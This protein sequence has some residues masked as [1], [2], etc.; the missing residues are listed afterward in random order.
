[1]NQVKTLTILGGGPAGLSAAYYAKK[2]GIDFKLYE[3][4]AK[5]GGN[6]KT[7]T[8]G[9][10]KFDT[11]A[12]RLHGKD[13]AVVDE[14][15]G[16]LGNDI[17]EIDRPS[18]IFYNGKF[19]HFPFTP[20]EVFSKLSP[21]T[22]MKAALAFLI[23]NRNQ[24]QLSFRDIAEAKYGSVI[25]DLF[26]NNYS[27]KLWGLPTNELSPK[28]SGSRLKHLNLQTLLRDIFLPNAVPKHMEG[29]FYYPV[30]GFG[31]IAEHLAEY[32]GWENIELNRRVSSFKHEG[33]RIERITTADGSQFEV[34]QVVSSLPLTLMIRLLDPLPPTEVLDIVENVTFR[35]VTLICFFLKKES[36][37]PGATI[38]FPSEKF[39]FTRGYE[40]RNRSAKMSPD[41]MTSFVVEVPSAAM[42]S[43]NKDGL[44]SRIKNQLIGCGLF[45]EA[46]IIDTT[47]YDIP[48]AYPVLRV[49]IEKDVERLLDYLSQYKNLHITG[50]NGLFEYSW[51]HDMMTIG[52]QTINALCK[53][54]E[55]G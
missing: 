51:T 36:V 12:H 13:P 52:K 47:S 46:D 43:P 2:A 54:L 50:R 14:I 48:Y 38:Y 6:C 28:I 15:K 25:S 30:E 41:G 22:G 44:L 19:I 7:V 16:L 18:Y 37:T 49:G 23:R 45:E 4:S 17:R 31:Q 3:A 8:Y 55:I 24:E 29:K 11:G 9:G 33:G 39:D 35:H 34:D 5:V 40:P 32:A 42:H 27:E 21:Y 53:E 1:M 10:F 26:L 20:F